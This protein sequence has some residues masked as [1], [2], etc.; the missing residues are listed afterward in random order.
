MGRMIRRGG[1]AAGSFVFFHW[2]YGFKCERIDLVIEILTFAL[3]G[4]V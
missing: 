4:T 1:F 3:I 2:K